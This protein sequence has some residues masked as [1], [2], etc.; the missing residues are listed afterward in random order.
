MSFATGAR[1]P[2]TWAGWQAAGFDRGADAHTRRRQQRRSHRR[3]EA[4]AA[5]P[6]PVRH[7]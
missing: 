4:V 5:A 7:N 6:R 1:D 2:Q 3:G